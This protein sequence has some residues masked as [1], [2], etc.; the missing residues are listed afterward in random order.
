MLFLPVLLLLI[1]IFNLSEWGLQI[2]F[3]TDLIWLDLQSNCLVFGDFKSP[4]CFV[5]LD[6]NPAILILLGL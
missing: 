6:L 5:R 4:L 3:L 1:K 2:F